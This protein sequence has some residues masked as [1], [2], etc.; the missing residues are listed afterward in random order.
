MAKRR[1]SGD[2]MVRKRPDGRWE[3]RLV[4]GHKDDSRPIF[5]SVFGKTQKELL[6]KLNQQKTLYQDV[7]LTEDSR[8]TLGEWLDKW[9]AE[10]MTATLR[11][12]TLRGY[13]NHIENHIK[14]YLGDKIVSAVT[15]ADV[16][17]LYVMLQKEGRNRPHPQLGHGLSASTLHSIHTTFHHAMKTAQQIHMIAKNPTEGVTVP[18]I[19]HQPKQILNQQQLEQFMDTLKGD[20]LWHDFFYTEV[21]TGLRRGELCGLRWEDFD[22]ETLKICRTIHGD[23]TEGVP[24]TGSG[25]RT[26][27]LPQSTA[28]LLND[29]KQSA[30]SPWIFPNLLDPT[31]PTRPSTAYC[32]LKELL[33]RGGLP[34]IRFHDLRHTFATH[35]LTSGVD[36]KTLSNILGHTKASFT[37]DTYTHVTGDMHQRAA[38]IVGNFLAGVM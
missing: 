10:Y 22:G 30:I 26:I 15:S 1:P 27:F 35:A 33:A 37:L 5:R 12:T 32:K 23:L 19:N 18:K 29:R 16:Q 6:E 3:G 36:A 25:L 28:Q 20:E 7:E 8:M 2:G 13:R 34:N 17:R 4:V 21:T 11:P 9:L 31:L 24:K 38:E 14:P